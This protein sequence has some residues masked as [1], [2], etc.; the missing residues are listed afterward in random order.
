MRN[1]GLIVLTLLLMV[2]TSLHAQEVPEEV[3]QAIDRIIPGARPDNIER[4]PINDL[5]SLEF[6]PHVIYVSADGKYFFRGDVLEISSKRNLTE[7]KRRRARAA[8]IE[9]LGEESM[10]VF[11]PEDTEHTITVFTDV[12]CGYC[13]KLHNDMAALHDLGIKV[14]YLAFPRGGSS[15]RTYDKMVSVWC[16]DDPHDAITKAKRREHIEQKK[17]VNPVDDHYN[18]GQLVGVNG[19]PTLIFENGEVYP[20]YAPPEQLINVLRASA[21]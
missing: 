14:R 4:S 10:I 18:M 12:D 9:K 2:G 3:L 16:A 8:S 19:T 1:L 21:G 15:S 6:G 20:G 5:Y 7:E 17:C 13:V 11:A